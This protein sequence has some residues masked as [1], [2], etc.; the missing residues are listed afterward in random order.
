MFQNHESLYFEIHSTGFFFKL[1]RIY[2]GHQNSI[3]F[4]SNS[5]PLLSITHVLI[6]RCRM[7]MSMLLGWLCNESGFD[8]LMLLRF[9]F[10]SMFCFH[11]DF[12]HICCDALR[13]RSVDVF[14]QE[15]NL[16]LCAGSDVVVFALNQ[17][18]N[19]THSFRRIYMP[20]GCLDVVTKWLIGFSM[21]FD[22]V[23]SI[24]RRWHS[25]FTGMPGNR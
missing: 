23:S 4:C 10:C 16:F 8:D 17:P 5:P 9:C 18:P 21:W 11:D 20:S 1:I 12:A 25:L 24:S 7:S 13:S 2:F 3:F 15:I 6:L 19:W 22:N 14:F